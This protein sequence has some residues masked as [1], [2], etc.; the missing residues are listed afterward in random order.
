MTSSLAESALA[1]R[2][3]IGPLVALALAGPTATTSPSVHASPTSTPTPS[4]SP[5]PGGELGLVVE[6]ITKAYEA[7][8]VYYVDNL[9]Y[10]AAAGG[11]LKALQN[12]WLR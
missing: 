1:R 4:A 10:A 5:S 9:V 2:F 11:E 7:E 3:F 6:A 12:M 8:R